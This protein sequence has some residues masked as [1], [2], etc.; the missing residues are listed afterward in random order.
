GAG[1][2]E[3]LEAAIIDAS[4]YVGNV[5]VRVSESD[6]PIGAQTITMGSGNDTVIFDDLNDTTAGLTI[7][8]VVDGGEGDDTLVIDGHGVNI[9]IS[10]SEWT[11]VKNFETIR[12][13]GN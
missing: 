7:S 2:A 12:L 5:V 9:T 3:R 8:D 13:V 1:A 4:E 6:G 11:N 10:A